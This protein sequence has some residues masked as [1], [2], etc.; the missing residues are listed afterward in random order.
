MEYTLFVPLS[1]FIENGGIL[2]QD[3]ELFQESTSMG[4]SKMPMQI[5]WYEEAI[6]HKVKE[7]EMIMVKNSSWEFQGFKN[8]LFVRVKAV[9]IYE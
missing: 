2:T 1:E 4:V 5:G 6:Q 9:P 8:L 7:P 3:R